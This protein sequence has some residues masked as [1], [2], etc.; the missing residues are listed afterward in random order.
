MLGHS[1][2]IGDLM[3]RHLV[4]AAALLPTLACP[5]FAQFA[6]APPGAGI[7]LAP[8][9]N[10]LLQTLG[11]VITGLVIP[12]LIA[13]IGKKMKEWGVEDQTLLAKLRAVIDDGAQKAIG[14]AIERLKI[15]PGNPI[16][17]LSITTRIQLIDDAAN[18][19]ARNFPD[20]LDKLG[21]ED[22]IEKAREII[23]SRLGLMDAAAA[24]TPVPNPSLPPPATAPAVI[25]P[26]VVTPTGNAPSSGA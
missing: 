12:L 14:G 26:V 9:V 13:F 22:H 25:A 18:A 2:S 15:A 17:S 11:L 3:K 4:V 1:S 6:P 19:L 20:A 23:A 24:G 16:A 5:A 8:I 21:V 10:P 7:D